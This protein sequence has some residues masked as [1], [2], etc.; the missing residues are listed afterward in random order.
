MA[1]KIL[2]T[3]KYQLLYRLND[4][5][6]IFELHTPSS[7]PKKTIIYERTL[8]TL[9]KYPELSKK[10]KHFTDL[11]DHLKKVENVTI[12]LSNAEALMKILSYNEH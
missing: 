9:D 12:Q 10:F 5:G 3:Q 7:Q 11:I 8:P 2:N 1:T 6:L 4:I